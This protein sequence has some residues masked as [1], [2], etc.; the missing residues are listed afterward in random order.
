M[1]FSLSIYFYLIF[2]YIYDTLLMY[3]NCSANEK[4]ERISTAK[5]FIA[6]AGLF[7]KSEILPQFI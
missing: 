3:N 4:K 6:L 1:L 2:L 5:E 7:A